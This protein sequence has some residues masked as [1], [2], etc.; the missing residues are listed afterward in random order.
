[1]RDRLDH[2]C[3]LGLVVVVA[4]VGLVFVVN[5]GSVFVTGSRYDINNKDSILIFVYM[6]LFSL[7]LFLSFFQ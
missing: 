5:F 7:P 2:L 4:F 3:C 1:M 6:L